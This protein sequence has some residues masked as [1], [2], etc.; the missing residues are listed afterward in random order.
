[1]PGERY[2]RLLLD[3]VTRTQVAGNLVFDAQ[4]AASCLEHG[5]RTLISNDRDFARFPEIER[6]ID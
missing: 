6:S 3:L 5:V 1:M 4:I 2:P